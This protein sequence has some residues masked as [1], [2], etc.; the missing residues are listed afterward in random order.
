MLN[1]K[2]EIERCT[3]D[4]GFP[5]GHMIGN[6]GVALL[7]FLETAYNNNGSLKK[8]V[9]DNER[10]LTFALC[11]GH[12]VSIGFN[13]LYVGAHSL[14]QVLAGTLLSAIFTTYYYFGIKKQ[15]LDHLKE[16]EF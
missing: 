1:K 16:V 4:F 14:D 6:T 9:S 3:Y 10:W 11:A 7:Y 8:R 13:R 5:S 15:F 12:V 2:I